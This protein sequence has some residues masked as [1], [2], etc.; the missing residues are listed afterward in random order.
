M[1]QKI[2]NFAGGEVTLEA[3]RLAQ[4]ADG[5]VLAKYGDTHILC[6]VCCS[7]KVDA[8]ASFFP[9]S[10]H[11][12]DRFYAVGRVPGGFLKREGR[13]SEREIILSRL[14]DR[15]IRPLFPK[16]FLHEVQVVC[17]LL[18]YDE[19]FGVET[20]ALLGVSAALREAGLPI[21][22]T[23]AGVRLVIKTVSFYRTFLRKW[24][25]W[26]SIF[27]FLVFRGCVDGGIYG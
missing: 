10:V 24:M 11:F 23:V 19:N 12:Q 3:G 21:S 20:P 2:I 22:E 5:S 15:S 1:F 8:G 4:R 14:I 25:M 9:L 17:V 13:P 16:G 27:L 6:T 26:T 18:S 7:K